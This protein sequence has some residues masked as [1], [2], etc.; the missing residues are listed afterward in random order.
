M[1]KTRKDTTGKFVVSISSIFPL[2]KTYFLIFY[3]NLVVRY[4][5]STINLLT[6]KSAKRVTTIPCKFSFQIFGIDKKNPKKI[7]NPIKLMNDA[8]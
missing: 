6:P 3:F 4:L 2:L 7:S 8:T 5:A 1:H